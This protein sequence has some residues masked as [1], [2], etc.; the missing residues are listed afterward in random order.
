MKNIKYLIAAACVILFAACQDK[1]EWDV[2]STN[3]SLFGNNSIEET[4]VISIKDLTAKYAKTIYNDRLIEIT[5]DIKI[6]GRV[7]CNDVGG[8]FYKKITIQD[9]PANAADARAITISIDESGIWGYLPIGQEILVALKGLYIGGNGTLAQLGTPYTDDDGKVSVGRMSKHIWQQHFKISG[10]IQQVKPDIFTTA[11][12]NE[13]DVVTID[14]EPFSLPKNASKLVV[15]NNV[16]FKNA[17]GKSTYKSG[18]ESNL[19]GYFIQCLNEFYDSSISDDKKQPVQIFTSGDYAKFSSLLLPYDATTGKPAKCC[20]TGIAGYY[21]G[22]WQISIRK[23]SDI[24]VGET[25]DPSSGGTEVQ[26]SGTGTVDDPF[27][28]AAAIKK[29][30]EVG[31]TA[32]S[33]KYYIKGIVAADAENTSTYGNITFDMVDN[34]N[35]A[36]KFTAYQVAGSDGSKL[37]A[38]YKVKAG[39][40]VVV[41]GAVMNYKDNK[42]ET[43]GKGNAY[44]VTINGKKTNE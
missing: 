15:F 18:T 12:M 7:T 5:E 36:K 40:V 22:I 31:K 24:Y 29:C 23:T 2:P 4:N 39:D 8:N 32:S 27:N 35:S 38:G 19:T 13:M 16:T 14:G 17:D 30:E 37:D 20:L 6:K 11:Y 41:Y 34:V 44:I 21:D 42:P 3:A 26:P 10:D 1:G 43:D 33:E 25:T 28:I 9:A